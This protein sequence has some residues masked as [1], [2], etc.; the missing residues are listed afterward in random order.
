MKDY[1]WNLG[2]AISQLA[3]AM[4][5]KGN[6]NITVSARC[7][8]ERHQPPPPPPPPEKTFSSLEFLDLFTESEQLAIAQLALQSAQAKLWYDRMLAAN[9]VVASDPRTSA[10]LDFLVAMGLISTGR[11]AEI[12]GAML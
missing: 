2:E 1:L 11:R 8:L 5:F 4:F 9:Y 3:H 7:Y 10:G 12:W 6:P